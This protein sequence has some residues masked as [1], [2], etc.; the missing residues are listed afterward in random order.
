MTERI[1]NLTKL[2][3]QNSYS[4]MKAEFEAQWK[5]SADWSKEERI[6]FALFVVRLMIVKEDFENAQKYL[7]QQEFSD[8]EK[9]EYADEIS[10]YKAVIDKHK[11]DLV[12][13]EAETQK[14]ASEAQER[15]FKTSCKYHVMVN[16]KYWCS[17]KGNW[18]GYLNLNDCSRY[19]AY[20]TDSVNKPCEYYQEQYGGWCSFYGKLCKQVTHC[21]KKEK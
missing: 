4:E 20:I 2:F 6:S 10:K 7:T 9:K 3:E 8:S 15:E 21:N 5:N 14:K 17:E 12:Q 13:N 19:K 16:G 18:C 11:K 1:K